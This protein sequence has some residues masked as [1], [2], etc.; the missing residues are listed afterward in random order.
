MTIVNP[1]DQPRTYRNPKRHSGYEESNLFWKRKRIKIYLSY[2]AD[3][4]IWILFVTEKDTE[5][6][7]LFL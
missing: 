5:F 3:F 6:E 1:Q 7:M 4:K 2:V